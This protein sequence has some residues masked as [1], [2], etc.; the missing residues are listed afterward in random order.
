[1]KFYV[2]A[3]LITMLP[4]LCFR[5]RIQNHG[6]YYFV[7]VPPAVARFLNCKEVDL[8]VKDGAIVMNP[9]R[10]DNENK[11]EES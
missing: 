3:I 4:T 5:R 6:G 9:V 7:S 11:N 10:E 1:V 2:N 8:E